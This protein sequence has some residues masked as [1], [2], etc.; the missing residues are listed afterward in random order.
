MLL[1]AL[2]GLLAHRRRFAGTLVATV[3]GVAFLS[4]TLVLSDTLRANFDDLFASSAADTDVVVRSAT[5]VSAEGTRGPATAEQGLLP[6]TV[7]DRVSGVDGVAAAVPAVT[8]Y[9]ELV[10]EDGA[11]VGGNGPP[12]QAVSWVDD[13]AL[14]PYRLAEGRAP[15]TGTEVVV[16]RGAAA[17]GGLS[18]GDTTTVLTPEPVEVTIVGL[19]TYGDADGFGGVTWVAFPLEAAQRYV[20][21]HPGEV[22]EVLVRAEPGVSPQ[23]LTERVRAVL[24]AGAEALTGEQARDEARDEVTEGFL[25]IFTT[26]L[27]LFAAVAVVVSAVSIANTFS[28][29]VAQRLRESALLRAVGAARRQVLGALAVEALAVGVVGS[30]LG[31]AGGIGIAEALKGLFTG[32]GF[33]LPDSGLVVTGTSAAVSLAVGIVVTV[34][35]G[36]LPAV[37]ASRVPPLAALRAI[38]A[39]RR[40]PGRVRTGTGMALVAVGAVLLIAGGG[41]YDAAGGAVAVLVGAILA[42]PAAA[43]AG[44]H[45]LGS[46]LRGVTGELARGNAVRDPRRTASTSAALVVGVGVVTLFTVFA[47]SLAGSVER[48]VTRSF[49]ADL[50]V[51]A[52]GFGGG[53]LSPRLARDIAALP[54]VRTA[55]GL[56]RGAA[57]VAGRPSQVTAADPA[58]LADVLDLDVAQGSVAGLGADGLAVSESTAADRGWSPGARVPVSYSDGA[59]DEL[60]V[61]AV[62]RS[63]GTVGDLVMPRAAYEAH[64]AQPVDSRVLIGLRDGTDLAAAKTAVGTVAARYGGPDVQDEAG[65]ADAA[66]AGIDTLLGVVYALLAL[67]VLT[68]LFGIAS[69]LSLSV[70]ERVRELGLLRAVGQSRRQ[71]RAMVRLE[72]VLV[73][74]LGTAAGTVLGVL[75]GW[76]LARAVGAGV[77]AAPP[78]TLAVVLVAGAVAGVLAA[79]R[80]ARRAARTDV[81]H[82]IATE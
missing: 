67:A 72:S 82:A 64:A 31:L 63:T 32:F 9:G 51:A 21:K 58:A 4:G 81:L 71:V 18:I 44:A 69:S 52:P 61:R 80:P 33:A 12:R 27:R 47:A 19:S 25:A 7:A 2:R 30:A 79:V 34:L 38:D 23:E 46:P 10:G 74:V 76:G 13:P 41:P 62:Y 68:A 42:G 60:T 36:L 8:G 45:V 26:F 54:E 75:L 37:R 11:S 29:V 39:G 50:V 55:V 20:T 14:T 73:S 15:R 17:A 78:G 24:P 5:T 16:N 57:V 3:L 53:A 43:A 65:Y 56:A 77:V 66:T 35:A 49:G 40:R 48:D 70:G 22:S 6:G 28:I 59:R 1:V